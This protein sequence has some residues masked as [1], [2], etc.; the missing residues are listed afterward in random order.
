MNLESKIIKE[1]QQL[2]DLE[3]HIKTL[4]CSRREDI[5]KNFQILFSEYSSN[6]LLPKKGILA[7]LTNIPYLFILLKSKGNLKQAWINIKGYRA[8]KGLGLFDEANYLKNYG[9]V[10]IS[11]INPLIHYMYYGYIE[12]KFPSTD[13]DGEY[14]LNK[15]RDVKSSGM[16]PLVHYSL[17][18][19]N[20]GKK[21][22]KEIQNY[23]FSIIFNF[24]T[25]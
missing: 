22:N 21:M 17:Y 19:V 11:G 10:L 1:H 5:Y 23:L 12:N 7:Q 24:S 2:A 6:E 18:G 25:L 4:S 14:Y 20:E 3:Q 8:I 13:F 9:N 15:Y 16:N